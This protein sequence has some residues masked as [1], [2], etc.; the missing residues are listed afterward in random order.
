MSHHQ[1][2][3][4]WL[5]TK[6]TATWGRAFDITKNADKAADFIEQELSDLIAFIDSQQIE[7]AITEYIDVETWSD[8][9]V[10]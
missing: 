3:L 10:T 9:D 4:D 6:R 5:A 8:W 2:I 7:D 1:D